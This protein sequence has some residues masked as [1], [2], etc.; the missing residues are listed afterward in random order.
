MQL[1]QIQL[2]FYSL[3]AYRSRISL[4]ILIYVCNEEEKDLLKNNCIGMV[5]IWM[6]LKLNLFWETCSGT[7]ISRVQFWDIPITGEKATHG[8]LLQ[9]NC[10]TLI[11]QFNLEYH[12]M[13]I[14]TYC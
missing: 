2:S 13:Q 14:N 12:H 1:V 10:S 6:Y 11:S 9:N 3:K 7:N 4:C 5:F 8:E